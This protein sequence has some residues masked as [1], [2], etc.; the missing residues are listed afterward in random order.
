MNL[1]LNKTLLKLVTLSVVVATL[2]SCK[3]KQ[4]PVTPVTPTPEL[5]VTMGEIAQNTAE[6]VFEV[7]DA[8][9][10]A[11][12]YVLASDAAAAPA[13]ADVFAAGNTIDVVEGPLTAELSE[14]ET[15]TSYVLYSA[16]V[17]QDVYCDVV[18]TPFTTLAEPKMLSFVSASRTDFTYDIATEEG[19]N[20]YH[21][22]FEGWFFEYKLA[23]EQYIEGD[24]FKLDVFLFNL[25]AEYG[26]PET[27]PKTITWTA[28]Q[29]NPL[30]S[31]AALL[32]PGK[33]YYAVAG[34]F[35]EQAVNW[36]GV[37]EYISFKMEDPL[38][39]TSTV[40]ASVYEIAP[41]EVSIRMEPDEDVAF[42]FY[43][44]HSKG[45]YDSYKEANGEEGMMNYMYEYGYPAQN[46]YTD[47]WGV[48]PGESYML[49]IYGVDKNGGH[50]FTEMQVD[51]PN[52]TPSIE[53]LMQPY[54]RE[55]Q[56]YH[57]YD[58]FQINGR[59][60][61]LNDL[62]TSNIFCFST[63]MPRE[64]FDGYIAMADQFGITG[65]SGLSMEELEQQGASM[66]A[67]FY[68]ALNQL[69]PMDYFED[70]AEQVQDRGM[71]EYIVGDLESATE[72]VYMVMCADGEDFY[73]KIITA[74]TNAYTG[75]VEASEEY[76]AY[77]GDW[78]LTG[79]ST[80]DWSTYHDYN[81]RIEELTPNVSYSVS[82][83]SDIGLEFP[84]EMRFNEIDGTV[85]VQV[86]QTVG[87][88]Q[89]QG[90]TYDVVFTG[91]IYVSGYDDLFVVPDYSGTAYTGYING[92]RLAMFSTIF[93]HN[94]METDFYSMGYVAYNP[95]DKSYYSLTS[96]D[97]IYFQINK[98]Q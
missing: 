21:T 25:L 56:G 8:T 2:F 23:Q 75:P 63:P 78:K 40:H 60:Q 86:P 47:T 36:T 58:S 61:H 41:E 71:F 45:S 9:Q 67:L 18:K 51:A 64:Q 68:A 80:L 35:D 29:E 20:Y 87:Q 11:Y 15:E 5:K 85:S 38:E 26:Y 77:L 19:Q 49:G 13:A 42:F 14:L 44:L 59:F 69:Y 24:E 52:H 28:G 30:R 73:C 6:V 32:V 27:S 53:L 88:V 91:K 84:F 93:Q 79:M 98:M 4:P 74:A 43:N 54:D 57:G 3:E 10:V 33:E 70:I 65:L 17:N 66:Y 22:Y 81:L 39:S 96:Y 7:S 34:L 83:W 31:A 97:L 37:P 90:V 1:R 16:A 12:L 46:L 48:A 89:I 55:M 50:F 92:S 82:G 95:E 72:Y 94:G 62:N 76:K